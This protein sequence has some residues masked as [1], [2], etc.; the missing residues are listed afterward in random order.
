MPT[1]TS[2]RARG[3]VGHAAVLLLL[4]ATAC[5]SED[6]VARIAP[7]FQRACAPQ[8][9][10]TLGGTQ[11]STD[12]VT[13]GACEGFVCAPH[14]Q[15][16]GGACVP[17]TY[18]LTLL[19]PAHGKLAGA[20]SGATYPYGSVVDLT[21]T[22]EV[23]HEVRGWTDAA[24]GCGRAPTCSI[25]MD[26]NKTVGVHLGRGPEGF[27]T[28]VTGGEGGE[29]VTPRTGP[30]LEA[31]LCDSVVS[32]HCAD[33]TPRIVQ[34]TSVIDFRGTEGTTTSSGCVNTSNGCSVNGRTEQILDVE[35]FCAGRTVYPVTYD[36]AGVRPMRVGSN[37]TIVGMGPRAGWMGKGLLLAGGVSNVIVRNL[38]ITDINEGIVWAGDGISV[39]GASRVWID[40]DRFA[41]IGRMMIVAGYGAAD[42]VT[43]SNNVFDGATFCG[44]YCDGRHYWTLLLAGEGQTVTVVGNV[45]R[46][47][48]GDAPQ[49]QHPPSSTAGGVVHVVNNSWTGSARRGI[50]A[51]DHV[52][53]LIEGNWFADGLSFR[54]IVRS[55]TNPVF[56]PLAASAACRDVLGRDCAGNVAASGTADFVLDP[57]VMTSI[58]ATPAWATRV[59]AIAP[60]DPA[61]VPS[62]GVEGAA[63]PQPDPDR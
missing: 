59:A 46:S 20:T 58:Q 56:A 43:I 4:A 19:A 34:L 23:G 26:G 21:A 25:V 51:S 1:T 13:W 12:G 36:A 47:T 44:S 53:T 49:V 35:S 55:S 16:S 54:P 29:V 32:G 10:F 30:E 40:H 63:G 31:A 15:P 11:S 5:A 39:D 7:T 18:A 57:T 6:A 14:Y 61:Q 2:R 22:P 24:A 50:V 3:A 60:L 41:R 42:R 33:A 37:K 52:V 48:A 9:A 28:D 17:A 27:A 8:P 62:T 45:F 38:S